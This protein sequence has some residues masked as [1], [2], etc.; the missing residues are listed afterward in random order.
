MLDDYDMD[1]GCQIIKSMRKFL[2]G[3]MFIRRLMAVIEMVC[4]EASALEGGGAADGAIVGRD[5]HLWRIPPTALVRHDM[6]IVSQMTSDTWCS[7][8]VSVL[9]LLRPGFLPCSRRIC[10]HELITTFLDIH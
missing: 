7:N 5:C 1:A 4:K 8:V 9:L 6:L 10:L 2:G 3:V